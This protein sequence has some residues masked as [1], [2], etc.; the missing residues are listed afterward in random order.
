[1]A[2]I[3]ALV[4]CVLVVGCGGGSQQRLVTM[5]SSRWECPS[6]SI[7]VQKIE[8]ET[9]RVAGCDHE[10]T[11]ECRDDSHGSCTRVSGF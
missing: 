10:A 9:F 8:S 4:V 7:R 3:R 5:A 2:K 11:Y 1:M 6:S